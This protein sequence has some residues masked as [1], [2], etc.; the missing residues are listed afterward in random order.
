MKTP[1]IENIKDWNSI[2]GNPLLTFKDTNE[3][4]KER[5]NPALFLILDSSGI[6]TQ[7]Y[8]SHRCMSAL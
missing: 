7:K 5:G 6:M 2:Q 8:E 4:D 3:E 1:L